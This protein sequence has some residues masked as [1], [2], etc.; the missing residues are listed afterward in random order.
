MQEEL[1]KI[2]READPLN[3]IEEG[4]PKD[5]YDLEVPKIKKFLN[6]HHTEAELTDFLMNMFKNQFHPDFNIGD[7]EVYKQ[8]AKNI[9]KIYLY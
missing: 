9:V 5:E 3:L 7:P 4:A 2:L 1:K 8:I 6:T